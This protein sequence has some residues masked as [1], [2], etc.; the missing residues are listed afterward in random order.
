MA[1]SIWAHLTGLIHHYLM[2]WE[3]WFQICHRT[4]PL[5]SGIHRSMSSHPHTLI[6]QVLS[7]IHYLLYQITMSLILLMNT[8]V[9]QVLSRT[10]HWL[11]WLM[12]SLTPQ[13]LLL[14]KLWKEVI[15]LLGHLVTP[16][17][18]WYPHDP[19]LH[20]LL[21][22]K[23]HPAHWKLHRTRSVQSH[24]KTPSHSSFRITGRS[25]MN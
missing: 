5:Y 9:C 16:H 10:R 3:Q 22:L 4:C 18:Q 13:F 12:M 15:V 21:R 1:R 2:Q 11:H 17:I 23:R 6:P 24:F 14:T 20:A 8:L 19:T 25:F 7:K